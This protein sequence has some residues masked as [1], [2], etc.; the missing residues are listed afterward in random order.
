MEVNDLRAGAD[1]DALIA[2][3]HELVKKWRHLESVDETGLPH[4]VI[5]A[6]DCADEL[7]A[8]LTRRD[9]PDTRSEAPP[10]EELDRLYPGIPPTDGKLDLS[11]LNDVCYCMDEARCVGVPIVQMAKHEIT[12]L[13]A[14]CG[15][16]TPHVDALM[17]ILHQ[18]VEERSVLGLRL[19]PDSYQYIADDVRWIL[20]LALTRRDA[21]DDDEPLHTGDD[22]RLDLLT[23][24]RAGVEAM[25]D[26]PDMFDQGEYVETTLKDLDKLDELIVATI[27]RE[28]A[29]TQR[30]QPEKRTEHW[31]VEVRR[32]GENLVTIES[33][34]LSGKPDFSAEEEQVIREAGRH[35]LAFIGNG[36]VSNF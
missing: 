9:Q 24:L 15:D 7:E 22:E 32:N 13:R 21:P 4:G 26:D 25:R 2:Q 33:N 31:S 5:W 18:R 10:P 12:V 14:A 30:D 36:D 19:T 6:S 29:L 1:L 8:L 28:S 23:G 34:C 3:L 16:A 35:L 11:L 20:A 27:R 17:K